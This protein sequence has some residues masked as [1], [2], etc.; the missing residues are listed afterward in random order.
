VRQFS[1]KKLLSFCLVVLFAIGLTACGTSGPSQAVLKGAIARQVVATQAPLS[2]QLRLPAPTLQDI[3]IS[4]INITDQSN[5][6]IN[7]SPAYHVQGTYDLSLKQSDH[8]ANQ[9]GDRFDVYVQ[10]KLIGK[11]IQWQTAQPDGSGWKLEKLS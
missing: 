11:V 4:H 10:S 8:R 9:T 3:T 1:V 5:L 6:R 2:Q 7:D